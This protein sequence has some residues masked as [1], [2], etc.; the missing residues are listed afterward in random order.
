MKR[1]NWQAPGS[2]KI[3]DSRFNEKHDNESYM[4]NRSIWVLEYF[5]Q[6]QMVEYKPKKISQDLDLFL[7]K[8]FKE[9]RDNES[10]VTH[11]FKPL[12]FFGLLANIQVNNKNYI[13]ISIDGKNFLNSIKSKNYNDSLKY[14]FMATFSTCY[15][16]IAAPK[17]K[18]IGL[19]PFRIL[20]SLIQK[21]YFLTDKEI[22]EKVIFINNINDLIDYDNFI[23]EFCF[24]KQKDGNKADHFY[25][26]VIN[27]FVN[28]GI[29]S[30]K[31]NEFYLSEETKK[32]IKSENI[33]L[34]SYE[35]MF[36][37]LNYTNSYFDAKLNYKKINKISL[38]RNRIL[39]KESLEKYK[40]LCFF[41]NNHKTFRTNYGYI[42]LESH[43]IIPF[44]MAKIIK[45]KNELD[46]LENLIPLCPNCHRAIHYS[47]NSN[48]EKLLNFIWEIKQNDL[49]KMNYNKNDLFQIYLDNLYLSK[50][51]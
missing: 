18:G 47:E 19:F 41:D 21:R 33:D 26:W 14:F 48:K 37:D 42:F 4:T 39:A 12:W 3:F 24:D 46:I 43:H 9:Y 10:V 6:K 30:K 27:S 2:G 44:A 20:Y 34:E 51:Y 17:T 32:I 1:Q 16:N 5:Y 7:R 29:L 22:K 25:T 45:G 35:N 38:Q 49:M 28:I 11:F 50:K 31:N 13:V 15:P 23:K 36:F 8:N 40:Y